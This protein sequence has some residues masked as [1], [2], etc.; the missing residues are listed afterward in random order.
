MQAGF[1]KG[2]S[3]SDHVFALHSIIEIYKFLDKQ[4]YVAFVDYR[5]AFDF[6]NRSHLWSKVLSSGIDGNVLRVIHNMYQKAKSCVKTK[7][8][9][10]IPFTCNVGVRQGEN[11][12]P[13]LFAIFLNDFDLELSKKYEGLKTLKDL[14]EER[15]SNDEVTVFVRLFSLL[16]ADDTIIMAES[17]EELQR[18]LD[19]LH[20]YCHKWKLT[21]NPSKTKVMIFS[22]GVIRVFPAFIFGA[23]HL[24]VVREYVYLGVKFYCNGKF[25]HAKLKQT[26]QANKALHALLWRARKLHLPVDMQLDLFDKCVSPVLLYGSEVW[27]FSNLE[28]IEVFYRKFAKQLLHIRQSASSLMVYGELGIEPLYYTIVRRMCTFWLRLVQGKESKISNMLYKLTRRLHY[29]PTN[30]F[31]SQWLDCIESTLVEID[32]LEPWCIERTALSISKNDFNRAIKNAL[33]AVFTRKWQHEMAESLT[34]TAYRSFKRTLTF[35]PYLKHL[36]FYERSALAKLRC[37]ANFLP[38]GCIDYFITENYNTT[39]PLCEL[40]TGDESHFLLRCD[41]FVPERERLLRP[42]IE[43]LNGNFELMLSSDSVYIQRNIARFS[44]IVLGL[45]K[46]INKEKDE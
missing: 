34:C 6:V 29:D 1:R 3:T 19:A 22:R 46:E 39:C 2:F 36:N 37:R 35:E 30:D 13:I 14:F 23:V 28:I 40:E 15:L 31:R 18:A 24:E 17:A 11:L 44:E 4:L 5:K 25:E 38:V 26:E 7:R 27:G 45:F 41:F 9:N 21:V 43:N 16:Y 33:T 42:I 32:M 8:G 12:S 20:E 10:T